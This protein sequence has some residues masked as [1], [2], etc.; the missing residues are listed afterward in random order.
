M[1]LYVPASHRSL[2]SLT[3]RHIR[4]LNDP[5][6]SPFSPNI[7]VT[8]EN[9]EVWITLKDVGKVQVYNAKSPFEQKA[10]LDTG[11]ITNHVNFANNRNGK[12][13]Y[14]TDRRGERSESVSQRCDTRISCDHS[15]GRTPTWDL[16]FGGWLASLCRFGKRRTLRGDRYCQQQSH[17]GHPDRANDAGFGL[18][19]KRRS[20]AV[21][22]QKI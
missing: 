21:P 1:P 22:A 3:L 20:R 4:S 19:A 5:Q 17:R 16:A 11:P 7:A 2:Q 8:P 13:A 18:C 6:V 12:F 14:V 9:D 15:G 10:V